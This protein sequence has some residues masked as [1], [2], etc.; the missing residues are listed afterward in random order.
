MRLFYRNNNIHFYRYKKTPISCVGKNIYF[1]I[2]GFLFQNGCN[3]ESLTSYHCPIEKILYV[4]I[5]I[6]NT[7]H[8][9]Y[10]I[11]IK[12]NVQITLQ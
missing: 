1:K 3:L 8:Y 6:R 12:S 2:R 4:I 9:N 5:D 11:I 7:V 10:K